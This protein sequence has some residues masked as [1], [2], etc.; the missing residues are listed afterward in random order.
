MKERE[1]HNHAECSACKQK[2][3][4]TGLPLFWTASIKRHGI[5]AGPLLGGSA[6]LAMAMGADEDMT[7]TLVS[8]DIILCED[9]AMVVME[10]LERCGR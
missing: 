1:L 5:K 4:H 10:L 3:G 8:E 2:I 9:C 6:A 7:E